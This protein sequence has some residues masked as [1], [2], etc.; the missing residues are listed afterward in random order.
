[1]FWGSVKGTGYPLHSPVSP[2]LPLP[3]VTVRHHISTWLYHTTVSLQLPTAC[4]QEETLKYLEKFAL[5][6][7]ICFT[8]VYVVSVS[9]SV[10]FVFHFCPVSVLFFQFSLDPTLEVYV[11]YT[12]AR[13]ARGSRPFSWNWT[14]TSRECLENGRTYKCQHYKCNR[15]VKKNVRRKGTRKFRRSVHHLF[16]QLLKC[17]L[18]IIR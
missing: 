9:F 14:Q 17:F 15:P 12:R 13:N 2:S 5:C 11:C 6:V 1:M 7:G 16:R 3:C 18:S 10:L 4:G 8:F